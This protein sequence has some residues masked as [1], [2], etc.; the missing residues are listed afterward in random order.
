MHPA[1]VEA[2]G[3]IAELIWSDTTY[4]RFHDVCETL[5]ISPPM[6]KTLLWLTPGFPVSMRTIAEELKV[7]ASWVTALIDGLEEKGFVE[8][9]PSP[10]DRRVKIVALTEDGAVSRKKAEEQ[11]NEPPKSFGRLTATEARQL[12]DLLYKARGRLL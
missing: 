11:L 6:L 4:R 2:Y 12:R 10:E 1:A 7:D 8:R 5:G 9:Q 3:L